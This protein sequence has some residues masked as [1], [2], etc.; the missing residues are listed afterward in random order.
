MEEKKIAGDRMGKTPPASRRAGSA[1]S[2]RKTKPPGREM[3]A[4]KQNLLIAG[5]VSVILVLTILILNNL[6]FSTVGFNKI[7]LKRGP[8]PL[9]LTAVERMGRSKDSDAVYPLIL[10]L[11]DDNPKVRAAAARSLGELG[12]KRAFEPLI[13]L[14]LEDDD[15]SV[16]SSALLAVIKIAAHHSTLS[17]RGTNPL[18]SKDKHLFYEKMMDYRKYRG[19]HSSAYIEA[20][21]EGLD[22]EDPEVK[23]AGAN[24]YSMF[25]GH[26]F[27]SDDRVVD[28][29]IVLTEDENPLV[30]RYVAK[31]LLRV[32]DERTKAFF[33]RASGDTDDEVRSSAVCI[34]A[35]Y[36][37]DPDLVDIFVKALGD[38]N[39]KIRRCAMYGLIE[40]G[41]EKAVSALEEVVDNLPDQEQLDVLKGLAKINTDETVDIIIEAVKSED[42]GLRINGIAA[43]GELNDDRVIEPLIESLDDEDSG[44]RMI[45]AVVL[46]EKIDDIRVVDALIGALDDPNDEVL[47][48]VIEAFTKLKDRRVVD[49]MIKLLDDDNKK[50]RDAAYRV[51]LFIND[52][53]SRAAMERFQAEHGDSDDPEDIYTYSRVRKLKEERVEEKEFL[54]S[55]KPAPMDIY[56]EWVKDWILQGGRID[57]HRSKY[58]PKVERVYVVEDGAVIVGLYGASSRSLIAPKGAEFTVENLGH[59]DLFYWD[60]SGKARTLG[61]RD[62]PIASDL[63][64]YLAGLEIPE[65]DRALEHCEKRDRKE[66]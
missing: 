14:L 49:T 25:L 11:N 16:I 5:L 65:V 2:Y 9:K 50:V 61:V 48:E 64:G 29:L 33:I 34:L 38:S 39:A 37:S 52:K 53:K 4:Q 36:H 63:K 58:M 18:L 13:K 22:D 23:I 17:S 6:V 15:D 42:R 40:V 57:C 54:E 12:S 59:S 20:I 56:G 8:T 60:K 7:L 35:Q 3:S 62:V 19:D 47:V 41:N 32:Y 55:L 30:K 31:A 66:K 46:K 51:L 21:L 28:R 44:V 10:A 24:I 1:D 45:A 26:A 43:L 27:L